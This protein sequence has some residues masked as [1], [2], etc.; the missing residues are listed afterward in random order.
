MIATKTEL[1]NAIA[2]LA[3]PPMIARCQRQRPPD[4]FV[5]RIVTAV[6]WLLADGASGVVALLTSS[7]VGTNIFWWDESTAFNV[8]TVGTISGGEFDKSFLEAIDFHLCH[9]GADGFEW[10]MLLAA[11]RWEERLVFGCA[12]EKITQAVHAIEMSAHSFEKL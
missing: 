10:D 6:P 8:T 12:H 7:D 2:I 5:L 1:Y 9:E 4:C 3:A 11:S